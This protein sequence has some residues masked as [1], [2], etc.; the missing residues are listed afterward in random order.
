MPRTGRGCSP[1][2]CSSASFR[3]LPAGGSEKPDR[4]LPDQ[5]R[6]ASAL[7]S[8]AVPGAGRVHE[9]G[10]GLVGAVFV[11]LAAVEDEDVLV[12]GVLVQWRHAAWGVAEEGG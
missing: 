3:R 8:H 10:P 4:L 7:A 1:G 11:G 12:A 5:Q 9:Q 6:H 2:S